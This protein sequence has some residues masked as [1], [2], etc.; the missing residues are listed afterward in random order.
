M[1][2]NCASAVMA[3]AV[4]AWDPHVIPQYGDADVLTGAVEA[5]ASGAIPA[6]TANA[7]TSNPVLRNIST[8][9]L[10]FRTEQFRSDREKDVRQPSALFRR[11]MNRIPGLFGD[12][13]P[14]RCYAIL[15]AQTNG[16]PPR[17]AGRSITSCAPRRPRS[18]RAA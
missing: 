2:V 7:T 5:A 1:F 14:M 9:P 18:G 3:P 8:N 17:E 10:E 15:M 13:R 4:F 6:A 11:R 12:T 16:R